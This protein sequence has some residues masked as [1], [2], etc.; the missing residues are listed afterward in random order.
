MLLP[1]DA[2]R[3]TL[4]P[5]LPPA[6]DRSDASATLLW[7]V[8]TDDWSPAAV[9]ATGVDPALLPAVRPSAEVAGTATLPVGEV[10][11][12]TGGADTPL[13]LLAAGTPV[14]QVNLGTGAQL[15][16]PGM[17]APAGP[18][19]GR[20]RL[21]RRLGRLVRD[22]GAA[23]RRVGVAVGLRRARAELGRAVRR[24]RGDAGRRRGSGLPAVPQRGAGRRRPPLRP[25][26]LERPA[27]RDD[28]RGPGPGGGR[29]GGLRDRRGVPAARFARGGRARRPHR[30]RRALAR[31]AAV[32]RRRAG[33]SGP[34]PPAAQR[35]GDRRGGAGRPGAGVD[36][37]PERPP[38]TWSSPGRTTGSTPQPTA[39]PGR[40][41]QAGA[42]PSAAGARTSARAASCR[43]RW[44]PARCRRS[45]RA[46]PRG[47]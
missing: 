29:G 14:A 10:P 18:R 43:T 27:P 17:G 46:R 32:A 2:L 36:V 1:K 5:H 20:A 42:E 11:V 41:A 7:D 40:R 15:L 23:E 6:T 35:L 37:V 38:A 25:R 22:G 16:R 8:T 30:R 44:W 13:A 3:A 24:G 34:A 26:R 4:L 21:R 28:P 19:A 31:R 9:A 39:G 45:G 33:P 47:R 12:V